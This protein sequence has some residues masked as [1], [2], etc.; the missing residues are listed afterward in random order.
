MKTF[1]WRP[2][3]DGHVS[4]NVNASRFHISFSGALCFYMATA[5]GDTLILVISAGN[6]FDCR[7]ARIMGMSTHLIGI[8]PADQRFNEMKAIWDA[9]EAGNIAPPEEVYKFFGHERPTANGLTVGIDA[10]DWCDD[11]R[12][13]LEIDIADLPPG[14]KTLRFYNS[15]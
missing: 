15:W 8:M 2:V 5:K 11:Y 6:W 10:R 9:C 14:V 13:G 1:I 7:E 12:Q 3:R 4:Y